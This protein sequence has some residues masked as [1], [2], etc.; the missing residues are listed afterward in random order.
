MIQQKRVFSF[1]KLAQRVMEGSLGRLFGGQMTTLELAT[2]VHQLLAEQQAQEQ[3]VAVCQL[4]LHPEDLAQLQRQSTDV[5]AQISDELGDLVRQSGLSVPGLP[6]IEVAADPSLPAHQIAIG[7]IEF[8]PEEATTQVLRAQETVR[9]LLDAIAAR[10][11][12]FIVNGRRHVPLRQ[13]VISIGR[14]LDNDIVL[15][16]ASVS[17]RH[18]QLR[19]RYGRFILYDLG[20][21]AGTQVNGQP[22]QEIVLVLGDVITMG[23]ATLIYGEGE[24]PRQP[25]DTRPAAI[26]LP[27]T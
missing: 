10:D 7:K 6:H 24:V 26:P 15:D 21:R 12:F 4:H 13:A 17:R 23:G 25:T 16:L 27:P 3:V 9:A 2:R 8:A 1:E 22:I 18:A 5:P 19:W 11:A 20:S 14:R